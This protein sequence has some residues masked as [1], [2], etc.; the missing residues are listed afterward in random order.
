[1]GMEEVEEDEKIR[2]REVFSNDTVRDRAP[3]PL[4]YRMCWAKPT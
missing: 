4:F 2:D 3:G 1:M